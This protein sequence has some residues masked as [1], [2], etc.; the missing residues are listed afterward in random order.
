M[1]NM[2]NNDFGGY[3]GWQEYI[4]KGL[5]PEREARRTRNRQIFRENEEIKRKNGQRK[6][7]LED[8][9]VG[10]AYRPTPL[11]RYIKSPY[12]PMPKDFSQFEDRVTE[13]FTPNTDADLPVAEQYKTYYEPL[14]D[15]A[16]KVYGPAVTRG[17]VYNWVNDMFDQRD[18]DLG[19]I[20][21]IY[22]DDDDED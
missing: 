9:G 11:R 6:S 17:E 19:A 10:Y 8:Y 12:R 7:A 5:A 14:F 20:S 2:K 4:E 16:R 22:G 3:N 18:K 1:N 21:N 13:R 15:T